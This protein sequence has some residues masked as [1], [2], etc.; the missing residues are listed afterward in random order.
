MLRQARMNYYSE[1]IAACHRDPSNLFKVAKH[2]LEGS[3]EIVLPV[4][5]MSADHVQDFSD[6]SLSTKLKSSGMI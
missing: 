3:N 4:S 2:L 6:F 5:K 1:K